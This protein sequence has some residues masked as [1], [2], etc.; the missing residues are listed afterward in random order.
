MC[1]RM[2]SRRRARRGAAGVYFGDNEDYPEDGSRRLPL[3]T[4][5]TQN[6]WEGR[7]RGV[8]RDG[9]RSG[10]RKP[11]GGKRAGGVE[12]EAVEGAEAD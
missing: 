8:A 6:E 11:R 10:R 1:L 2:R 4:S 5:E 12:E 9:D 3:C 7:G